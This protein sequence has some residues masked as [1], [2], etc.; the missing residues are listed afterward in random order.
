[1]ENWMYYKDS[2]STHCYPVPAYIRHLKKFRERYYEIASVV[3]SMKSR[4]TSRSVSENICIDYIV[5]GTINLSMGFKTV[6]L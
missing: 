6:K 1:M 2:E 5:G 4:T 3:K